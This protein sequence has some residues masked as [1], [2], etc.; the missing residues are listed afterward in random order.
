MKRKLL[1]R[2]ANTID[3]VKA[4]WRGQECDQCYTESLEDALCEVLEK[5]SL[6]TWY[7]LGNYGGFSLPASWR[8]D[9]LYKRACESR[10]KRKMRK[11]SRVATR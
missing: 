3:A 6:T 9:A 7:A 11:A 8:I 5:Q 4:I 1:N 10:S 2:I